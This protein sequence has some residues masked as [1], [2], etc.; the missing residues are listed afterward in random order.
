[1]QAAIVR[2]PGQVEIAEVPD[3]VARAGEIVVKVEACGV[4]G[5]DLHIVDGEFPA[6]VFPL[7]PRSRVR[8]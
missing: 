1:M 3:P 4:C 6:A 7:I 8:G 5:T 2:A